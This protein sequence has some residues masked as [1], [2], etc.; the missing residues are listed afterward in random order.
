MIDLH[1]HTT[2]SDGLASPAE[3]V[4]RARRAGITA[5]G[6]ADHDTLAAVPALAG[7]TREAG[8]GFVPGLEITAVWEG[9]DVHVLAYFVDP[10][11][12][13]LSEFLKDQRADR[14]RRARLIGANLCALGVP[15]DVEGLIAGCGARVV[16]RPLLARAMVDAGHVPDVPAAFDRYLGEGREAYVARIGATP[17]EVVALVCAEGGIT[18]LAHPGVSGFDDLIPDLAAAGLGALEARHPDHAP[19]DTERYLTMA[20][21]LGLA[22]SGGSDYHGERS[23][24]ADGLGSVGLSPHEFAAFCERA[25]RAVPAA[26]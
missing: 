26:S 18:S 15:V 7:L 22:I 4:S 5:M 8:L 17:F 3:L 10:Q 9:A 6:I 21:R 16:S 20:G 23:H 25:G 14:L 24:H 19:A 1:L 13:R 11:S 12:Q 2:A